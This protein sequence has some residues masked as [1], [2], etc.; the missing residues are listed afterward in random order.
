MF[1]TVFPWTCSF[2]SGGKFLVESSSLD[3][4][5]IDPV[6]F[7]DIPD[8]F[9][10]IPSK[11]YPLVITFHK[12]LMMLDGTVG[13]SYFSRFP[14][15]H[16]PSRTVTL[17]SFIRSREV[18]YERFISSY[19][20][21]FK[22]HLI[23]YLDSSAVFT[24]IISHIKGGLEAGKAHDGRLSRE[25][26]L[27]LS[28]ARVSNLTREQRDRVY[29][30]FLEYEKKKFKKGEYDLSD[31]VMDLHFRLR[32]ERY[33]G[34]HI[35]FVYIDEVQDLTMRQIALFKYVSKNIDEGFVFSGDTA[36][37]I[38]KGVHFRFQDIRHLFFKE[39]V[40]GSRTDATDEKKEK[41]KLSK[42][43]H[44]SQNFRTH[45][46][47][48]NL[49][50]S[51]IDLLYHFFPLTIDELNPETSLINGEAP[52]LI[53]CGNFRDALP[54]IFGDSENAQENVGF[55]AEQV[56]L[57]RNDSAKEEISKYV[58]KKA[59]VLTILEC[60]GLEFRVND[61]LFII[62]KF[63][64]LCIFMISFEKKGLRLFLKDQ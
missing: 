41:G 57:V 20:P 39:F 36:Q 3:L 15:A 38:A 50:Q 30:I 34:D 18:N 58:G 64:C 5:Y 2:A 25:D 61:I 47:V 8:S 59:L 54:T 32:N 48:L 21:Y 63:F 14:D 45:A 37:T 49:A 12:F 1:L 26:Y 42:I 46:G 23:K 17:Q 31:L 4:D 51:I 19:W 6:Q 28:E 11:S 62:H 22:S 43:F 27:L 16:K 53:E 10:N 44:L 60:K 33:E 55:G 40:L 9:V 52:V 35:D 56:I 29:D 24:E 13:I 7:K